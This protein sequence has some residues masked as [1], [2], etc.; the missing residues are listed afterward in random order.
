MNTI[1]CYYLLFHQHILYL[2][3]ADISRDE[4][5]KKVN[6]LIKQIEDM[7]G[8]RDRILNERERDKDDFNKKLK[9]AKTKA[10]ADILEVISLFIYLLNH[11]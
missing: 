8:E 5:N 10:D 9:E 7:E 1:I 2:I 3:Y 11:T 4:L 6:E